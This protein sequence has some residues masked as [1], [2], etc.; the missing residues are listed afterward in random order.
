MLLIV[1]VGPT[2]Q[3]VMLTCYITSLQLSTS[4]CKFSFL[5][6]LLSISTIECKRVF[7]QTCHQSHLSVCLSVCES[8]CQ[9]SGWIV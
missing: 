2:C 4:E 5:V 7:L 6:T 1:S 3:L 9:S 8:V